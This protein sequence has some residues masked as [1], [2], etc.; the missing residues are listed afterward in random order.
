MSPDRRIP[1]LS[2]VLSPC[3]PGAAH[4]R[5]RRRAD[6]VAP[7][8]QAGLNGGAVPRVTGRGAAGARRAGLELV[9]KFLTASP[10]AR[11][12]NKGAD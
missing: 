11:K 2:L 6:Q 7:S 1:L 9:W 4:G 3:V 8:A 5:V 10:I 12:T